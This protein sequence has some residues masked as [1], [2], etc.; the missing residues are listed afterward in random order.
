MPWPPPPLPEPSPREP[1]TLALK[2]LTREQLEHQLGEPDEIDESWGTER[3][4]LI[5]R[6]GDSKNLML[7]VQFNF[8]RVD[9]VDIEFEYGDQTD[10]R[11]VTV[12]RGFGPILA[13]KP[14]IDEARQRGAGIRVRRPARLPD[15]RYWIAWVGAALDSLQWHRI[16]LSTLAVRRC[17]LNGQ[18]VQIE[19]GPFKDH[20]QAIAAWDER[21]APPIQPGLFANLPSNPSRWVSPRYS[22][23]S[24]QKET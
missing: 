8:D 16:A 5:Y 20:A 10:A 21:G 18:V 17:L 3:D 11:V 9:H 2:R 6:F 14:A 12:D 15:D 23:Q 4:R 22:G 13:R 24:Q 19:Q 7:V 1:L